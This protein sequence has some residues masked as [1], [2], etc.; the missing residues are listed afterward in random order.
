MKYHNFLYR[1]MW[2][3]CVLCVLT[4]LSLRLQAN[5]MPT[6]GATYRLVALNSGLAIGNNGVATPGTYLSVSAVAD[7][8]A[9][10]EWTFHR[11]SAEE[12]IF[13][14]YNHSYE[15]A[16]D[17]AMQSKQPGRLLQWDANAN[18]NQKFYVEQ[19]EG[20]P[21]AVRLCN[22]SDRTLC[23]TAQ[24][25]GSLQMSHI[26][27]NEAG[28]F[29]L[30]D[31][32]KSYSSPLLLPDAYYTIS[33]HA[34]GAALS[35][36]GSVDNDSYIY[37]DALTEENLQHCTWQLRRDNENATYFQLYNP[38]VGKAF[39]MAMGGN[40]M[41]LQWNPSYSNENQQVYFSKVEVEENVYELTGVYK[42]T[43]YYLALN[44]NNT[45]MQTNSD[46]ATTWFVLN[47]VVPENLP[48]PNVWEDETFFEENKEKAHAWY[49]PYRSTELMRSD[50]RYHH[51][52]LDAEKA[53]VLSLNGIWQLHYVDAPE[54]RPGKDDFWGDHVDVSAWDT[55][56]VPSCLEMK[57]YG[58]PYYINVDY[59][60]A[61]NPPMI[62]MRSGLTN[63][64]ASYRRNFTL[65]EGWD[66]QRVFLHFDGIYSAAFVWM[67]GQYVGYTQ[68][69]NNDSEFD[70]TAHIRTGENNV[71]VQVF[72]WCDGSYLEGQDMWHMS[73][74]HRDVY[75]FATPQTYIRDHYI[76]SQLNTDTYTSGTMTVEITMDN[77]L[78]GATEK[79]AEVRCL[80][81]DGTLIE[82]KKVSFRFNE[83]E[84]EL[85]QSIR[86]DMNNLQ[87]WTAETPTLYTVEIAQLNA[88][89]EEEHVFAT[90]HGFRDIS[91]KNGLIYV[92]GEKVLFK[93]ANLQDTHPVHGRSVDVA[94]M[95]KDVKMFKQSNMNTVRTSHYPRQAKMYAMF[96][97]YGLYCM[98]EAD[99]ECHLNWNNHGE[100]GGITNEPSWRAQ[101]VDRTVRMV[102]RD[103][104]F[105]S[106]FSWS[107]GN[108]SGGGVNF[109]ATFEA[110]RQLDPRIIHYEGATR[111][112]TTPTEMWSVMYPSLSKVESE[113]NNNWRQQPYF[114]CEYAHAMGNAVGNL[115]E[116]W[117]LIESSRFGVGGCIWDWADQSIYDADDIK[118]NRLQQNGLNKYRTG[119]DYPGPHQ[120]NFVNNGL[121]TADR[122]WSPELTE[123]KNVYAYIKKT[124]YNPS[125][126][127]L[128]L[129]NDYDFLSLDEF[130]VRYTVLKNGVVVEQGDVELPHTQ[131]GHAVVVKMPYTTTTD[132]DVEYLLNVECL[133]KHDALWA[134]KDYPVA[135]FQE[136]LQA[137][138]KQ[139][140]NIEAEIATC[141]S[142][143]V[144]KSASGLYTITNGDV[145]YRFTAN[146]KWTAWKVGDTNLLNGTPE[147][148]N[149][150]WVE[151]DGPNESLWNYSDDNGISSS[152]VEVTTDDE[153][154]KSVKVI[155]TAQGTNCDYTFTYLLHPN[156]TVDLTA[157]YRPQTYNLRRI[158]MSMK[159]PA[160][161]SQVEYYAR[162][163]WENYIDR[164]SASHLG[165]YTTTVADMFEPYPKPQSMGNRQDLRHLLLVQPDSGK[166]IKVEALGQVAFSLL[167]YSDT[168]LKQAAHT[169]ELQSDKNTYAHFDYIQRGVGNGSCGQNTGTIAEYHVPSS[170]TY[171][172]GLRFSPVGFTSV[173][174]QET[175]APLNQIRIFH[176]SNQRT[177]RL[178]G[179]IASGSHIAIY[180]MGG[181]RMSSTQINA[182]TQSVA[183]STQGIPSGTYLVVIKNNEGIRSHKMVL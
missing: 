10:Q 30:T 130:Y 102:L 114:M 174:I 96:D 108:E 141:K 167:P 67:N 46:P 45:R 179:H 159:F 56:S 62:Q 54:K 165:Y 21:N 53:E 169:W 135:S 29:V 70:V 6:S 110:V 103:R 125:T 95:L 132:D 91:I 115:K 178:E 89:G 60:F 92:N 38:Y 76:S 80:A 148:D 128:T 168:M 149:Y 36:R 55:I 166:G 153:Y 90:K 173:G 24:S 176:Q 49:V 33:S 100:R 136:V 162:G 150:R 113:A 112:G 78:A 4:L 142:L 3:C 155:T 101:Y 175:P 5:E 84:T 121:V 134:E 52:W 107:L 138:P 143:E 147:Y 16:M 120:G 156:G 144:S 124:N 182:Q 177:L 32:E 37:A 137:Q 64:V 75:L 42:G 65:P 127:Q 31:V 172:Y 119:Y 158:G 105:P 19:V 81:P 146:G 11:V 122:A 2:Q 93:G 109:N 8:D 9:G 79:Q 87:L 85:C 15:Q 152:T 164:Q 183:I 116:Y 104:N 40:R 44:G 72:R 118:N 86:F 180:N 18:T 71:C 61:D 139:W 77:R 57:G 20:V 94:T 39:D 22:N 131:P 50:A 66:H 73:G 97:Y 17:M 63:S 145:S 1:G 117:E 48:Q 51:P 88:Q 27:D 126:Q 163:P 14:L 111:G 13:M 133:L 68:G 7:N 59:A 47:E 25:D 106:I 99:L 171:Q 28:V 154:P 23:V 157:T 181:V 160:D 41:P 123:V 74:I 98:D 12:P 69:A 26:A 34:T 161:F 83:G 43:T 58:K 170:G 151:N 140:S 82:T 35:N 129:R